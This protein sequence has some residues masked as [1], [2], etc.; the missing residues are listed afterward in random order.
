[1]N[2][3]LVELYYEFYEWAAHDER[4][5][6]EFADIDRAHGFLESASHYQMCAY[7]AN[8]AKQKWRELY[9][10]ETRL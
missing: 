2:Q 9:I 5:Y 10:L 4:V 7:M 1:M 8:K 3:R 6:S